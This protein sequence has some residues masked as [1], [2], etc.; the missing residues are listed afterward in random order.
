MQS[1]VNLVWDWAQRIVYD[2]VYNLPE[3]RPTLEESYSCAKYYED[4]KAYW[5]DIAS[6]IYWIV[7]ALIVRELYGGKDN[8]KYN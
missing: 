4:Y 5:A 7:A 2:H 3:N 8:C 6:P 1:G